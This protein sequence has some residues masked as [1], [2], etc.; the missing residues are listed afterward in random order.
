MEYWGIIALLVSC[1]LL[2]VLM[3]MKQSKHYQESLNEMKKLPTG[4]IGVG[5][6]KAKFNIGS[7]VVVILATDLQGNVIELREMK[8]MTVFSRF[9]KR[10]PLIGKHISQ[11]S[12]VVKKQERSALEQAISLINQE[13]TKA[14]LGL[15]SM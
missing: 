5:I 7:G 3:S 4:H 13:R 1:W 14:K 9:K 15:L 12:S 6:A 10:T 2:Q 8:G 11:L